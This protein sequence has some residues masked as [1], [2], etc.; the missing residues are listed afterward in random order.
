M[1]IDLGAV[2]VRVTSQVLVS[3]EISSH[4]A[5]NDC[6]PRMRHNSKTR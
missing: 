5:G 2:P 3:R 4:A 1:S 6:N